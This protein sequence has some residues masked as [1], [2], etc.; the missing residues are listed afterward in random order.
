MGFAAC[1]ALRSKMGLAEHEGD[2]ARMYFGEGES[3]QEIADRYGVSKEAVRQFLN[4]HFPNRVGGRLFRQQLARA[5]KEL[6]KEAN[7][8]VSCAVCFGPVTR[9]T[10]GRG[11]NRTC[12]TTHSELWAKARFLLDPVLRERQRL[13]IARS[14]I[15]Y[16]DQ[17]P[18]SQV[19][20][21]TKLIE[22]KP[23]N[24]KAYSRRDS[25]AQRAYD[26]VMRIRKEGER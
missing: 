6:A 23:I 21:A 12:S 9:R 15:R 25:E 4:R 24:S 18:D 2:I 20:W 3:Y 19:R 16:P 8:G 10:G 11:E 7:D 26:E 14:I 5:E 1:S 22:G 13:S 17:H